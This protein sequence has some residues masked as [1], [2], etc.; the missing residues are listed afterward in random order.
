MKS[1]CLSPGSHRADRAGP[2]PEAGGGFDVGLEAALA[3]ITHRLI[4]VGRLGTPGGD[5]G[6]VGGCYGNWS[7]L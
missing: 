5:G 3:G 6:A 7:Q 1:T 2:E 4:Q